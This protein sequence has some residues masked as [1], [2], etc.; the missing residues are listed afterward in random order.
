MSQAVSLWL[1]FRVLR[2]LAWI[3][4]LGWS[5]YYGMDRTP[6]LNS[7]GQ[8]YI[9]ASMMW[10]VSGTLGVFLGCF[11]LMMRDRAGLARA[12]FGQLIPPQRS[13]LD[14]VAHTR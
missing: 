7:F 1:A 13:A 9:Y 4:F 12:G 14:A 10:F 5:V 8:L 6:H 3:V 11:E 2:W